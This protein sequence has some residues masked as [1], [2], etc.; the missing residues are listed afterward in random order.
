MMLGTPAGLAGS[1]GLDRQALARNPA[2][3]YRW[4]DLAEALLASGDTRRARDGFSQA[5]RLGPGIPPIP[6]HAAGF[7]LRQNE[8][9]PALRTMARILA[10]VPNYDGPLF[11]CYDRMGVSLDEVLAHGVP[12]PAPRA[13]LGLLPHAPHQHAHP[14]P[15]ILTAIFVDGHRLNSPSRL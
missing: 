1:V 4:C 7:C 13:R 15:A 6:L 5:L 14:P 3:P 10:L 11:S 8:T 2:S 12:A 9:R